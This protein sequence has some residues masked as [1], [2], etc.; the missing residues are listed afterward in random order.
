MKKTKLW[1]L[2]LASTTVFA[3]VL[4]A[5][6]CSKGGLKDTEAE[7]Q[8]EKERIDA[9]KN[10]MRNGVWSQANT[11]KTRF[12]D[13]FSKQRIWKKYVASQYKNEEFLVDPSIHYGSWLKRNSEYT[14]GVLVRRQTLYSPVEENVNG[15]IKI[16]RPSVWKYKLEYADEIRVSYLD[17]TNTEQVAIFNNDN[18]EI[19]PTLDE[20]NYFSKPL[21]HARSNDV[22]SINSVHFENLLKKGTKIQFHVRSGAYW[23]NSNGQKTK[24]EVKADDFYVSW[25]RT[26]LLGRDNRIRALKGT[27]WQA[28]LKDVE[29]DGKTTKVQELEL[30]N[31]ITSILSPG[32]KYYSEQFQFPNMYLY[33]LYGVD[34]NKF[35]NRSEFIKTVNGKEYV[36]IGKKDTVNHA[37]MNLL[38]DQI[39]ISQDFSAAPS[40]Y[41]KEFNTKIPE[42][43]QFQQNEENAR[44]LRE[45]VIKL[46]NELPDDNIVKISGAY[47]YGQNWKNSLTA[48]QY[49]YKGYE[50]SSAEELYQKNENYFDQEFVNNQSNI[51]KIITLYMKSGQDLKTFTSNKFADYVNGEYSTFA[52]SDLD[53]K[54]Q[55]A[56]RKN[57]ISY[58]VTYRTILNT[59]S[60]TFAETWRIFPTPK[61][62]DN[63]HNYWNDNFTKLMY[64]VT[65]S[66]LESGNVKGIDKLEYVTS[67]YGL[68]FR[69][70]LTSAINW[71][72][73]AS[74]MTNGTSRAWINSLAQDGDMGGSDQA[75]NPKTVLD[76][77]DLTN[78]TFG[79]DKDGNKIDSTVATP[80]ENEESALIASSDFNK[81]KS[82]K[83][84]DAKKAMKELLDTFYSENN[85]PNNEKIEWVLPY[86]Y[87]NFKPENFAN[88]WKA[89]VLGKLFSELDDRLLVR[90][91]KATAENTTLLTDG[92][93][94][95]DSI[96][97]FAGWGYDYANVGSGLDGISACSLSPFIAILSNLPN[98]QAKLSKA[99]PKLVEVANAFK[100]FVNNSQEYRLSVKLEDLV[101][102]SYKDIFKYTLNG[103]SNKLKFDS[104]TNSLVPLEENEIGTYNSLDTVRASFWLEY[105]SQKTNDEL[106]QLIQ[107]VTNYVSTTFGVARFITKDAQPSLNNSYYQIPYTSEYQF[108]MQDVVVLDKE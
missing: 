79:V 108:W 82:V 69:S 36:T 62:T 22:Q 88:L 42:Y 66:E 58:G 96:M 104:N 41:I 63:E 35:K 107:E 18:A 10:D 77:Y 102:L 27:K 5:G 60:S 7:K 19:M 26:F 80:T 65:K 32:T 28:K 99:F 68:S 56:I 6:A 33:S 12:N 72:G 101:K 50:G 25:L 103:E 24:Y 44:K 97:A 47:W 43:E 1:F 20:G 75:T 16:I 57:P 17:D 105:V 81:Y 78:T 23:I 106:A 11:I 13:T 49:Y 29:S 71:S 46:A 89:E 39:V 51:K 76:Y 21:Y 83:F 52:T 40:D 54:E 86:R 64:G 30:D 37:Q 53:D 67:G 8:E 61:T 38:F 95:S 94:A 14:A 100:D 84:N 85:I 98:S 74:V 2:P 59:S 55:I 87:I 9:I 93:F 48:G 31:L 34:A 15:D 70:I 91:E 3:P 92:I 73:V 4:V 90:P 45:E